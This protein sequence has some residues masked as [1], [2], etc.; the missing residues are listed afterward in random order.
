MYAV[1][2]GKIAAY[3]IGLAGCLGLAST[4]ALFGAP[5]HWTH[6]TEVAEI[7]IVIEQVELYRRDKA[8]YPA[9][10]LDVGVTVSRLSQRLDYTLYAD[11]ADGDYVITYPVGGLFG[12]FD[13][14][15]YSSYGDRWS[16]AF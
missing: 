14:I 9:A 10:L 16:L 11:G 2:R 4:L 8:Q 13:Q 7:T 6:R 5:V 15:V 1:K 12:H 3:L